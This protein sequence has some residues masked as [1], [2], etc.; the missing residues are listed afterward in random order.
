MS[1]G[2]WTLQISRTPNVIIAMA[3]KFLSGE[4]LGSLL[5]QISNQKARVSAGPLSKTIEREDR[6]V[7]SKLFS[8]SEITERADQPYIILFSGGDLS[9][10]VQMPARSPRPTMTD[11]ILFDPERRPFFATTVRLLAP[12]NA[13]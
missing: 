4:Q 6:D 9:L 7:L 11:L 5:S 2:Q 10:K 1:D 8:E 12:N 3:A 13:G